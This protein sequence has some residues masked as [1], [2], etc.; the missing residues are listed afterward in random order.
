MRLILVTLALAGAV[1]QQAAPARALFIPHP[2][3]DRKVIIIVADT[4]TWE[5]Y[6]SPS[7]PFL[8]E[9][10][11]RCAVGL[12]NAR[13]AGRGTPAAAYLTLGAS[14]RVAAEYDPGLAQVALDYG[15]PYEG[16][17]AQTVLLART[18]TRLPP[19]AVAYLGLP[20]VQREN[21]EAMYPLRLGLLGQ[22]LRQAGLKAAAIG[23]ADLPDEYGRQIAGLV[24]DEAGIVPLGDVGPRMDAR[25]PECEPP[26]M[27]DYDNLMRAFAAVIGEASVIAVETGDLSRISQRLDLLTPKRM[28][29][30]RRAAIARM[31]GFVRRVVG[32]MSGR[33]WRLYLVTPRALFIPGERQVLLTP[34]A[35]WGEGIAPGLLTGPST[36]RPGV[37]A[38]V[39]L[40]PSVLQYLGVS[41][42]PEAVG[43]PMTVT[44]ARGGDAVAHTMRLER[45]QERIEE[46]RPYV[47]QRA[48]ALIVAVFTVIAVLLIL[49][50]PIPPGV[51][52]GLREVAGLVMAFPLAALIVP[53]SAAS[54]PLLVF[55][56]MLAV[57]VALYAGFRALRGWAPLWAWLAGAFAVVLCAD[58]VSGQNLVLRSLLS[59]SAAVGA[60]YYGLGN[61]LGGVLLAA[62]PLALAG[63]LGVREASRGRRLIAVVILAGVVII[64]G[65]PAAGANFG[66]AIPAALGYG[67][68][69]LGLYQRQLKAR[70]VFIAVAIAVAAA[71]AVAAANW[72]IG[73]Q[74]RSHIGRAVEAV[75]RG[76]VVEMMTIFGRRA[77]F[78]WTLARHSIA[79]W[80]LV[81]ALAVLAG[82][83]LGRG[84]AL[85]EQAQAG[86]PLAAALM[87]AGIASAAS[88]ILNDSGVLA[89]AWGF[90]LIAAAVTHVTFDW[91]LRQGGMRQG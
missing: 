35:A 34:I 36:R 43:R 89:A 59:Y 44:A 22:A 61:E 4:A 46:G 73:G 62:V 69:A 24:M 7:A 21:E 39:D 32:M 64:I 37:V 82:A 90:A 60:R 12:M 33:P 5:E 2:A 79:T 1:F 76:G 38:N 23:N 63:W 14:S 56:M 83:T 8:R 86:S 25:A 41:T 27:T 66:I 11:E 52:A 68:T 10:L 28:E 30:E 15:E 85:L 18:G 47:L 16:C 19:G 42:P 49:A 88:F 48:S 51:M 84:R 54:D 9:W 72:L 45:E 91:R 87:G 57:T 78:N 70:H 71:L 74:G 58:L 31:D 80:V 50:G 17:T 65:Y 3:R 55:L 53:G 75:Q 20:S 26:V 6:A 29:Q 81:S 40:A 13:T 67:L 77:A